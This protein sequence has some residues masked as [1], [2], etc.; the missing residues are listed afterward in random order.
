MR[1]TV[2]SKVGKPSDNGICFGFL[3]QFA[4]AKKSVLVPNGLDNSLHSRTVDVVSMFTIFRTFCSMANI[5]PASVMS[6]F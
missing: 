5:L 4:Y 1:K 2:K 3:I 6:G